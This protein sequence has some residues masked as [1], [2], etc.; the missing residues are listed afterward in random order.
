M[1]IASGGAADRGDDARRARV[2]RQAWAFA[3]VAVALWAMLRL[4]LGPVPQWASYHDLADTRSVLGIPRAGDVLSNVAILAAGLWGASLAARVRVDADERLAYR[5]LVVASIGTA[6]GSAVYH[7]APS[8]ATLFWDRLPM[9]VVLSTL[10]ALVLA[11]RIDARFGREALAPFCLVAVGGVVLWGATE[12]A[13]R[14]DLLLYLTV[15]VGTALAVLVLLILRPGRTRGARWLWGAV[16]LDVAMT[17]AERYDHALWAVTGETASGHN[18]KHLLAGGVLA[19][20][21]SWL[22]R[23]TPRGSPG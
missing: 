7:A 9:A 8:N 21:F 4:V 1:A 3:A 16:G 15:R 12:A 22:A 23:R 13:G 20:V 5:L 18:M 11:D 14:G 2:R 19:C 6:I 10:L 17:L